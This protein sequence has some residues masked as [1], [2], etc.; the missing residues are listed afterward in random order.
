M[1]EGS[2]QA[3]ELRHVHPASL[4][5]NRDLVLVVF[6]LELSQDHA[7]VRRETHGIVQEIGQRLVNLGLVALENLIPA[8]QALDGEALAA[9]GDASLL[10][11]GLDEL[12]DLHI[13]DAKLG[14]PCFEVR[15]VDEVV[16]DERQVLGAVRHRLENGLAISQRPELARQ[17]D[18]PNSR[19]AA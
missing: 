11:G 13:A 17:E 5:V 16:D 18:F 14:L 4:V 6:I 12:S 8:R 3:V 15:Q 19:R 7:A 1:R 9:P 2:R 10:H